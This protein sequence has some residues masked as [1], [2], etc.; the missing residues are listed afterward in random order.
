MNNVLLFQW[1]VSY[2]T[3][4][5]YRIFSY[6]ALTQDWIPSVFCAQVSISADIKDY[7]GLYSQKTALY[8]LKISFYNKVFPLNQILAWNSAYKE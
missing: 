8:L 4:H 6:Y 1:I 2:I 7:Y 3:H 5:I